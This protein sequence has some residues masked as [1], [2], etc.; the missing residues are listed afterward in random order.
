MEYS[1]EPTTVRILSRM[2]D[3]INKIISLSERTSGLGFVVENSEGLLEHEHVRQGLGMGIQALSD[4][5]EALACEI[6]A[7]IQEVRGRV[8]VAHPAPHREGPDQ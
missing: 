3:Q 6:D 7:A 2:F 1:D 5:I 8:A 4:E